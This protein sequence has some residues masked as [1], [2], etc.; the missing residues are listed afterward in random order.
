MSF[1]ER[2]AGLPLLTKGLSQGTWH[3]LSVLRTWR[4]VAEPMIKHVLTELQA[5]CQCLREPAC[6]REALKKQ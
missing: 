4:A 6:E 2:L 3:V 5:P 1:H